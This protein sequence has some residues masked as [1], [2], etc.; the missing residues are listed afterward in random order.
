[1]TGL[2]SAL[3]ERGPLVVFLDDVHWAVASRLELVES[4]FDLAE[5]AAAS[6]SLSPGPS[7]STRHGRCASAP[8]A[9]SRAAPGRWRSI[10]WARARTGRCSTRWSA[11]PRCRPTSSRAG[12]LDRAEG[13]SVV[14]GGDRAVLLDTGALVRENGDWQLNREVEV[15]PDTVSGSSYSRIDR[16]DGPCHEVLA[17][18]AVL[19]GQFELPV[20]ELIAG[21]GDIAGA[22]RELQRLEL[23]RQGRRWPVPDT[24]SAIR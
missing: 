6:S 3:A 22:L 21:E 15:V 4:L 5:D 7:A 10:C 8:C 20:L 16:L 11:R 13:G 1:M 2:L 19:G 23:L 17:A 12:V 9:S 14:P 18:A 24:A